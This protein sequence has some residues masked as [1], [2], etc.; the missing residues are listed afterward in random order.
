MRSG[1]FEYGKKTFDM[2]DG[3]SRESSRYPEGVKKTVKG[4]VERDLRVAKKKNLFRQ[5]YSNESND[6]DV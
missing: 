5:D 1:A 2:M 3:L 6:S 4:S